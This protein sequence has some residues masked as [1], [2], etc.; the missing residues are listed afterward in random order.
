MAAL[1]QIL[2][3]ASIT[4]T[5]QYVSLA[6]NHSLRMDTDGSEHSPARRFAPDRDRSCSNLAATAFWHYRD[7]V[8][9]DGVDPERRRTMVMTPRWSIRP[10]PCCECTSLAGAFGV[11]LTVSI[12]G[13]R[14]VLDELCGAISRERLHADGDLDLDCALRSPSTNGAR[15]QSNAPPGKT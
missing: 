8:T 4:Q 15:S 7:I 9:D 6:G 14:K 11:L 2:G 1:Q 13:Y 12:A 3:H 10:Q 5:M